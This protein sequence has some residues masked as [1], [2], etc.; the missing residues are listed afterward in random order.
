MIVE[1]EGVAYRRATEFFRLIG[2]V[3]LLAPAAS[4]RVLLT[5]SQALEL[6]FPVSGT[7]IERRTAFLTPEQLDAAEKNAQTKIESKVWTYYVGF[8][9]K[10]FYG[11]AYFESHRVRT[12]NETFMVVVNPDHTVR[13]VEILSFA[14]P[15]DYMASK[16]WLEQ[17]HGKNLNN[18]LFLRRGLRNITGA[19][20]TSEVITQGV[21]RI[22]ALDR[23][24]NPESE[25]KR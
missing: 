19:S 6:A 21:R 23:E 24:I 4:A 5:Q 11:T 14:E 1:K 12:M 25:S 17:F 2:F 10:N 13:S 9:S 8:S 15:D 7:R 22:L 18:E 3:V 16:P 20:L